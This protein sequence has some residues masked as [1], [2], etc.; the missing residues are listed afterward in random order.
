M[1]PISVLGESGKVVLL[2]EVNLWL[3]L[4]EKLP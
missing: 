1:Q 2:P 4:Q 3:S